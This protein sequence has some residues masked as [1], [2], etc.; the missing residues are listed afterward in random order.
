MCGGIASGR[1]VVSLLVVT[2]LAA[3]SAGA[4]EATDVKDVDPG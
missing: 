2:L 1:L 4:D 3:S